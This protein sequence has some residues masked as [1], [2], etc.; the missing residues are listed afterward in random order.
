[1]KK[2]CYRTA[3]AEAELVY[4]EDHVSN[5]VTLRLELVAP[6]SIFPSSPVY[7]LIWT[8]TPWTLPVNEAV[9]YSKNLIYS[10]VSISGL[11]GLYVICKNSIA[12]LQE[13]WQVWVVM[14]FFLHWEFL[15]LARNNS[16]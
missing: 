10:L 13:K 1:M 3:L 15:F 9:C 7:V 16:C 11:D 6:G 4:K 8:T 12:E 5:A 14:F 2:F